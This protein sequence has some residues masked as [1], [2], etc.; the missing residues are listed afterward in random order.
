[1]A[2]RI[3]GELGK[4]VGRAIK[5]AQTEAH[6]NQQAGQLMAMVEA[7]KH[8]VKQKKVWTATF[9]KKT[10]D[11]HQYLDGQALDLDENFT[12]AQGGKGQAPGQLGIAA[13][14]INCRCGLRPQVIGFEGELRRSRED[15]IVAYKTYPEYAKAK[16]WDSATAKRGIPEALAV[17]PTALSIAEMNERIK[18]Y[19]TG[20]IHRN[21]EK[22]YA[23]DDQG[24]VVFSK[25]GGKSSISFTSEEAEVFK[26]SWFTHNHPG[27]SSF[28]EDDLIV[29]YHLNLKEMRAAGEEYIYKARI[30]AKFKHWGIR[31]VDYSQLIDRESVK[32]MV[33][34]KAIVDPLFYGNKITAQEA[35]RMFTHE[36]ML[37]VTKSLG[38]DYEREVWK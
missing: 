8:G 12:T 1:M 26:G 9:D 33:E 5:V 15:G 23:F 31:T 7:E 2:K 4:D 18:S 35:N 37:R 29:L 17:K 11:S 6:R 25:V 3:S 22:C 34:A 13:E 20:I 28:S 27:G 38:I 14:D 21:T 10:R 24:E 36:K 16:G 19:E 32:A 30:G